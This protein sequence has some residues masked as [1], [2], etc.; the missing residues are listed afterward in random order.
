M[1]ELERG[2]FQISSFSPLAIELQRFD[3]RAGDVVLFH[4]RFPDLPKLIADTCTRNPEAHIVVANELD[5]SAFQVATRTG[6]ETIHIS[7]PLTP[8][9][10]VEIIR[11]MLANEKVAVA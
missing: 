10:F 8:S 7:G 2:G 11:K 9:G 4:G 6:N 5:A 3:A 1:R